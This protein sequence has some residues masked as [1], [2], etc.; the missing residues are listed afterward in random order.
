MAKRSQ[1]KTA[2]K[3]APKSAAK[4]PRAWEKGLTLCQIASR[5]TWKLKGELKRLQKSY[6]RVAE[7][8]VRVR[9]ER[10]WAEMKNPK[11]PN[12]EDY[13]QKRLGL[14]RSSLYRYLTAYDWVSKNHSEWLKTGFTGTIPDM[15]DILDMIW[16]DKELNAEDLAE[17]KKEALAELLEK[18]EDGQLKKGELG[19]LRKKVNRSAE[20]SVKSIASG[21]RSLRERAVQG[22]TLSAA[23]ITSFDA[24]IDL[25]VSQI[26][27]KV[28]GFDRSGNWV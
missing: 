21:L 5:L 13:A 19:R 27:P 6:L 15:T 3:S 12:I 22:H 11:H 2:K 10:L 16:I 20:E 23:T 9:D 7:Q 8:L 14:K 25:V 28:A 4:D 24:L 1:K 17:T 18:A 26:P